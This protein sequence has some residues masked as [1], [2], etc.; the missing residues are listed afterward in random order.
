MKK[1]NY[2]EIMK[3]RT[4]KVVIATTITSVLFLGAFGINQSINHSLYNE[5]MVKASEL[6]IAD[7]YGDLGIFIKKETLKNIEADLNDIQAKKEE[8][9]A[10]LI[11]Q[12]KELG[13]NDEDLKGLSEVDLTIKIQDKLETNRLAQEEAQRLESERI[14]QEQA[15]DEEKRIASATQNTSKPSGGSNQGQVN[16]GS[17]NTPPPVS[18]PTSG[19]VPAYVIGHCK[20]YGVPVVSNRFDGAKCIKA[21]KGGMEPVGLSEF[22]NPD[23]SFNSIE[24]VFADGSVYGVS[25]D[26]YID[27]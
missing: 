8:E 9:R 19:G 12:A 22:F 24:A 25:A 21:F 11:A 18:P 16:S 13:F 1:Y 15:L 20:D 2:K 17:G 3:S 27:Q 4:G 23:G 14:A 6:G 26:G 7:K 5:L 10:G